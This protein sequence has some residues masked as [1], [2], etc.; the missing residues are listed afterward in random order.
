M[1]RN[2]WGMRFATGKDRISI[3]GRGRRSKGHWLWQHVNE[4]RQCWHQHVSHFTHVSG[5]DDLVASSQSLGQPERVPNVNYAV[6]LKAVHLSMFL[7][8]HRRILA[9]RINS[10]R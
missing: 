6:S 4:K 8:T 1:E 5:V 7:I 10:Y 3:F 9:D 2:G